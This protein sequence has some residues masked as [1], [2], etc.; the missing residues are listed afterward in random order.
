MNGQATSLLFEA[1]GGWLKLSGRAK[2]SFC[3]AGAMAR[4]H[5]I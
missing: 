1:S 2:R 3:G 5:G 4:F